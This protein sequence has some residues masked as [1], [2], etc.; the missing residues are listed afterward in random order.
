MSGTFSLNNNQAKPQQILP[1]T[2]LVRFVENDGARYQEGRWRIIWLGCHQYYSLTF[3][4]SPESHLSIGLGSW[5]CPP[6]LLGFWTL[7][8]L[9]GPARRLNLKNSSSDCFDWTGSKSS[10]TDD[11]IW[12]GKKK[13]DF[14]ISYFQKKLPK[15]TV[16]RVSICVDKKPGK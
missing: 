12:G 6:A 14:V 2:F 16:M 13:V 11:Q 1:P 8:V 9:V 10:L 7:F 5:P 3:W 4:S 15:L